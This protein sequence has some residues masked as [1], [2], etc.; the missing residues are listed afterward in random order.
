MRVRGAEDDVHDLGVLGDDGR[1]GLDG[2]LQPLARRE[3]PERQHDLPPLDAELVFEEVRV[4]EGHV[5]DAVGDR[6]D[7][8]QGNVVDVVEDLVGHL[9]HDD[10]AVAQAGDADQHGVLLVGGV[11]E[12]GVQRGH[13]RATETLEHRQDVGPARAPV[14]AVLV[15]HADGGDL[16]D[17]EEV[18]RKAVVGLHVLA[19]LEPD[20]VGIGI[21]LRHVVHGHGEHVVSRGALFGDGF[22][23][24]V[25]ERRDAA[26]PGEIVTHERDGISLATDVWDGHRFSSSFRS[27]RRGDL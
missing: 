17:V 7:L 14:D 15:L 5:R 1:Q 3:Q 19:D 24:V 9:A 21:A 8:L 2:I 10:Q 23:E 4:D 11:L 6:D 13:Q 25:R 18:G 26:S 20:A 12:H 16:R 22:A 27:P